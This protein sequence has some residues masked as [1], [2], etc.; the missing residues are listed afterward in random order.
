MTEHRYP[1]SSAQQRM[2][3]L[4]LLEPDNHAYVMCSALRFRGALDIEVARRAVGVLAERHESLRT[5]FRAGCDAPYAVVLP[6]QPVDVAMVDLRAPADGDA[7]C[8]LRRLAEDEARRPISLSRYP[9]FRFTIARLSFDEHVVLLAAHHI[10]ADDRSRAI[11]LEELAALVHAFSRGASDPLPPLKARYADAAREEELAL[12]RERLEALSAYWK[13]RLSGDLSPLQLPSFLQ[14][15]ALQS[16]RGALREFAFT[17]ELSAAIRRIAAS[18]FISPFTV[19]L[20][21]LDALLHRYTGREDL[22]VG[23]AF[24]NRRLPEH[25]GVVGNYVGTVALR[26]ELS[27]SMTFRELLD[28]AAETVAGARAHADLPFERVVEAVKP[29]RDPSSNPVFQLMLVM[30]E[31]PLSQARL[32]DPAWSPCQVHNGTSKFDMT[33]VMWEDAARIRGTI[34]YCTDVLD[35]A[36]VGRFLTHLQVLLAGAAEDATRPLHALPLLSEP[37]HRWLVH[38]LN[39]TET[40]YD[41]TRCVH[42]LF[43]DA[44]RRSVDSTAVEFESLSMSYRELNERSNR[45][46]HRL[47][48]NGVTRGSPVAIALERSPHMVTALLGAVKSGGFYVPVDPR[49]PVAWIAQ[50]LSSLHVTDL[51]TQSSLL[52]LAAA[53]RKAYPDLARVVSLDAADE[54]VKMSVDDPAPVAS[55]D[56]LAYVIF[57][58]GS[59][60]TPKGVAVKHKRVVNLIE[61]VNRTFSVGSTDRLLFVTSLCFDLS[62][63]DVFG[64]LAAGGVVSIASSADLHDP[65]RLVELLCDRSITFWDSAPALLQ[66][67]APELPA[68]V[69]PARNGSLRLVF[70]SG[71]WIPLTLPDAVRS[72]FPNARVIGLGG[73]TEA[74]VWS[75]WFPIERVKPEWRSIPYGRPIQNAKYYVLDAHLSPCPVGVA[76]DLYIGGECLA[77][78]YANDL[79]KTRER[80]LPDPFSSDPGAT[81]YRTGDLARFMS[82]G[83]I[84]FLGRSDHQVKVRGFRIELGEIESALG[85]HAAVRDAVVT[86]RGKNA[87]ERELVAYV[88]RRG[89]ARAT[90]T[91]LRRHLQELVPE[92]MIPASWV[93]LDRIPIT[94]NGKVDLKSLPDPDGSRPDV[95]EPFVAPRDDLEATVSR[96]WGESLGIGTVGVRDR[97]FDLGGTSLKAVQ[98]MTRINQELGIQMPA[99]AVF[100]APTVGQ[101]VERIRGS[102]PVPATGPC[103]DARAEVEAPPPRGRD[104]A[105]I[106]MAARFPGA[107]NVEEFWSNLR[108]GVESFT[109]LTEEELLRSGVDP[110]L[111]ANPRYVRVCSTI[112]EVEYFDAEFFSINPREAELMDP[113]HRVFLECAWSALEDAGY[114]PHAFRG[115]IGVFGGVARNAYFASNIAPHPGLLKDAANYTLILGYDKD[116]PATRTAYKLDLRGPAVGVQTACSTSGVAL[117]L[118]CQ[119]LAAGD[120]DMA[121]VGGCR[122]IVPARAGYLYVDGG[123]LSPDGHVRAFDADANGM[124]R[125]SGVGFVVVKRLEDA[126]RDGDTVRAVVRGSAVNNDGAD[127]IG[128]TAPS[129]SGQAAAVAAA[130]RSAGITADTIGYLEAHGTGTILGDPIEVSAL[131]KAFRE[132]T[133]RKGFCRLGSVKTNIG[134]LDAGACVASIIKTVLAL[135]HGEIPPTL[136]FRKPNPRIDFTDSPFTVADRL[137]E[138]PQGVAPRRAGVNSVGLGGTNV[139]IVLEQAPARQPSSP[140]LPFQLLLLSARSAEARDRSCADLADH[141]SRNGDVSLADAAYTLQVGRARFAHRR[142]AVCRDAGGAVELL[143]APDGKR[144]GDGIASDG[145]PDVVF[146]FPGQG[147][148]HVGMTRGLYDAV[149]LFRSIVDECSE[150]LSPLLGKDLRTLM[151]PSDGDS[152]AAASLLDQTAVAQPALFVAEYA[153]ARLWLE[154]GMHPSGMIGHSIGE[155]TAACLA[156]VFSLPD[157]L[158]IVAARARLMQEVPPGS[159]CAVLLSEEEIAPYLGNGIALAAVNAPRTCVLSGPTEAIGELAEKLGRQGIRTVGVRTSHAFHSQMMDPVLAPFTEEVARY[160]LSPPRMRFVSC[161]TG[162]WI[163]DAEAVDP[164]Y[165]ALQL[166]NPVR[167]SAGLRTLRN[168]GRLLLVEAGPG[169]V[170]SSNARKHVGDG[171]DARIVPSLPRSDEH[172][173]ALEG[174][175]AAM[176]EA[177]TE[178]VEFNWNAL[179]AGQRRC[180]VP[181]PTYPFE[182]KRYWIEPPAQAAAS[183]PAPS[184]SAAPPAPVVEPA[185]AA[186][187]AE[188]HP[189]KATTRR[190]RVIA[191][192]RGILGDFSGVEFGDGD[193]GTG[194]VEM[195]L[196][197]LLLTQVASNLQ[198]AF[199][200]PVRFRQLMENLS[201]LNALADYLD[202]ELPADALAADAAAAAAAPRGAAAPTQA[203]RQLPAIDAP[204]AGV[205]GPMETPKKS[206]G[207]GAQID[208]TRDRSLAPEQ[209]AIL[210]GFIARYVAKTRGSKEYT[211]EHRA[212][213]ADP[214][215]VTGFSPQL[216]ELVYPIVVNRSRGSRMWDIDGNEYVDLTGC[217]GAN[218]LGYSP[219]FIVRAIR[220]QLGRGIEIGPQH[221]LAGPAARLM[222]EITGFERVVFCNTGSE[223]VM[224]AMRL[225][226]AVS[227][228]NVIV[229]FTHSYHGNFDEVL[230]RGTKKLR[231]LPAAPGIPPQSV[232]NILVLD[233]GS[234]E[235][236]RIIRERAK[237]LAAVMVEPVQTRDLSHQPREFLHRLRSLTEELGIALIFD[238]LVTGFRVHLGGAQAHFGIRADIATYGKIIAAGMPIGAIAGRAKYMDALDGGFWK[239]GDGSIPEVGVTYFAGTFVRHPLAMAAS[240]AS[241]EY[242][243]KKGPGLQTALNRTMDRF[244]AE[245]HAT[246]AKLRAPVSI[247]HFGSA[248][249]LYFATESPW[250]S[251]FYPWLRSKGIHI[252]EN[253][254]WFLTAAHSRRDMA[255]TVKAIEETVSEMM[256]AGFLAPLEQ[257]SARTDIIPHRARVVTAADAPAPGA[258][259][260]RDPRGDVAWF[261]ADPRRAGRHR[262]IGA[263]LGME[264]GSSPGGSITVEFDPFAHGEVRMVAPATESQKEIWLTARMSEGGN[265]AFNESVSVRLRGQLDLEAL[266]AAVRSGIQRHEALRMTFTSDG[267]YLCVAP[268]LDIDVGVLDLAALPDD[269]RRSGLDRLLRKEVTEPF[270]LLFGPL[271]RATVV[272]LG[273]DDHQLVI[274]SHHIVCDGWSI[275]VV[276]K[277]IGAIYTASKRNESAGLPEA[278][279]YSWYA[280]Y[281]ADLEAGQ[282]YVDAERYWL[283]VFSDGVPSLDLPTD[284]ARPPGRSFESAQVD[285]PMDP[286][287]LEGIKRTA[288]RLGCTLVTVLLAGFNALLHR[289][290]GQEDIV[291]GLPAAG[292][293]M[294]GKDFLVGH[295]VNLLPLRSR[296]E[297]DV[298]FSAYAKAF[299]SVM[300]DAYEH[301]QITFGRLLKKMR[302]HRDPSRI[303]LVSTV[304]NIDTGIDLGGMKFDDLDVDFRAN[305]RAFE[306][307]EVFL[308]VAPAR[309]GQF[310]F[311]LTYNRNLFSAETATM[312]LRG[313]DGLLRGIVEDPERRLADLPLVK[314][315]ERLETLRRW[316]PPRTDYP[317]DAC[318]HELVAR[319]AELTPDAPA[320]GFET[321]SLTYRQLQE[322]AAAVAADLASLGMGRGDLVGVLVERSTDMVAAVLGVLA[323]GAAYVPLDPSFPPERLRST[324]DDAGCAAVLTQRPLLPLVPAGG[325]RAVVMEDIHSSSS[326]GEVAASRA[327]GPD[328]LAYVI[329]TSGSTGKPKG[330]EVTHRA[331]VNFLWSMRTEPGLSG[332]DVLLAVT[333]L[334]F[335]IAGLELFLPLVVGARTVIASRD[336][337]ADGRKLLEALRSSGATVMQATPTTWRILLEAGWRSDPGFR[338][339]CG[340]EALP[341]ELAASIL[342]AGAELWNLYGPTETTIWSALCR[343][344]RGDEAPPIGHPIANTDLYVLD[345]SLQPLP[346]GVPGELCIGGE[347]LARGYHG[348]KDLTDEKFVADPFSPPGSGARLY[349]TGDLVRRSGD[350]TL[351]FLGRTDNQVKLRGYRVELGD[352]EAHLETHPGISQS[353]A[354]I[355]EGVS[356]TKRLVAYYVAGSGSPPGPD[357]LREYL[358]GKLPAYMVPS[359]FVA[360]PK[361]PLTHNGKIDRKALPKPEAGD[362][363]RRPST[364][365]ANKAE[366]RLARLWER[367]LDMRP[368]SVEESFFDLGGDSLI[369]ARMFAELERSTGRAMPLATLFEHPTIRALAK[370]LETTAT[371]SGWSSLVPIQPRGTR[372]PLFLVHGAEGNVLLYRQLAESLGTDQPVFGLQSRGLDGTSPPAATIE[373]MAADYVAEVLRHDPRGPYRLGGYCMGG[374]VAMEMAHRL[375]DMGREVR[376]L[377]LIETYNIHNAS[378]GCP[379]LLEMYNRLENIA[380]HAFNMLSAARAG[381]TQFLRQ[382]Y[383]VEARRLAVRLNIAL[384]AAAVALDLPDAVTYHHRRI[385]RVNEAAHHAYVPRPYHGKIV[386][387]RPRTHY[388][389]Y[390]DPL[391]GWGPVARD[392]VEVHTLPVHPRGMLLQP[393]VQHL[394]REL[395]RLLRDGESRS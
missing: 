209:Q 120:C 58:S 218:L 25:G 282:D 113:Q 284:H 91:D 160:P 378:R 300:L 360:I 190:D 195:G 296:P 18:R 7:S 368:V 222:S 237:D 83:N 214:R 49:W 317:R 234:E 299:R 137:S 223:A 258:R 318:V 182:R 156:G 277:D 197:S 114:D 267:S 159:M 210:D 72:A 253:R 169:T 119:S 110:A 126:L 366:A 34:E 82:D 93:F 204:L 203:E 271:V 272:R 212:H 262:R 391:F 92:Y 115:S 65:A 376:L 6:V 123:T 314:P 327:A 266:R 307:F 154:L 372:P 5:V 322:R 276:V 19:M 144:C 386:L 163:S 43:E 280:A 228:R 394:A 328:D 337:A 293:S 256:H 53:I 208:R 170:L 339:L 245:L 206:F 200:V 28:A 297:A 301:Q 70:L 141:L 335:D 46:A 395:E 358:R 380:Y 241:L 341:R 225:V 39:A 101:L 109:A 177:W 105:I 29:P 143:R 186:A 362:A 24:D 338:A 232:E 9:L 161:L 268:S 145:R 90:V 69:T 350:G 27:G 389:G 281:M 235:S 315:E 78:G 130:I 247:K 349:R 248:C 55:S 116:Y 265:C 166:R 288:S 305:P 308:N 140:S 38:D 148:Q 151:F 244:V 174:F 375:A 194:F 171:W 50:V 189:A 346:P 121:L 289:L 238:E 74:T 131:A 173:S 354:V 274:T 45:L 102:K 185:A 383:R 359:L 165:W 12:T 278:E 17:E 291:V 125:G 178:G 242:L 224:G 103:A 155:Y 269:E 312:W 292:Q 112:D 37:E 51:V 370:A 136:N 147:S 57:T 369:A 153:L 52:P 385:D 26:T 286:A 239:F 1:L 298:A 184:A 270:D 348:R 283:G 63:Y 323:S 54:F 347:G 42:E 364:P 246:F 167:F 373:E 333:T 313:Y 73:A 14:R 287:L 393:F 175:L 306:N 261:V 355:R 98:V 36:A 68:L 61:W 30:L 149:P 357:E 227:G 216:K 352:I 236:L 365:P 15:P 118:A 158:R 233:Y 179:H 23:T 340:G 107:R 201:S 47:R 88:T 128:F 168:E 124:V 304:F 353:A 263:P 303:P 135:E 199:G 181:L 152:A 196:D 226:R 250:N 104:V 172:R 95:E 320:V 157:A 129:V 294:V 35:E 4:H 392:G 260:G 193:L 94:A 325:P 142:Y 388:T 150:E 344:V 249:R 361:M 44:V 11:L 252:Y 48:E 139:H 75:N 363:G 2:W 132:T 117:H 108:N 162:K 316:N 59:T 40:P 273:P 319:Q 356:G 290:T 164:S 309:G 205:E 64:I 334:S 255:R 41:S 377:A 219:P 100:E 138:W 230:V 217:F 240:V 56:D 336:T 330:V 106:G 13:S 332:R 111:L 183:V 387:F 302:L 81:M 379:Q 79:E 192:L 215:T 311:E 96:I 367:L 374:A 207:A 243:K 146:M 343:V 202:A 31:R 264:G 295:C 326:A 342:E 321:E 86:A 371:R 231:S 382:K 285:L 345:A 10:I 67:L 390:R 220:R 134:H 99:L 176:G 85:R 22:T 188:V 77:E 251:L 331:L 324:L 3:T 71:D 127:K 329:Y 187:P 89:D 8:R 66:Q 76:G 122:I 191:K 384:S 351:R 180:R 16:H 257:P 62:V 80:F 254:T 259:L 221:P 84:E 213:F 87:T 32:P 381:D 229:T 97:F 310:V 20:A 60:G 33:C 211:Q 275:D 21:G 279:R 133:D 198:D